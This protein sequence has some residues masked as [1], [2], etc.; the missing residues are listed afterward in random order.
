V[1]QSDEKVIERIE[2]SNEPLKF[3]DLAVK[4]VEISP[5]QKFSATSLAE[6]G[7]GKAEDWLENL[8][9]SLKNR[10]NKQIVYIGLALQFPET[11]GSGPLMVYALGIGIPPQASKDEIKYGNPLALYPGDTFSYA[12]SVKRLELIKDFLALRKFQIIEMNKAVIKLTYVIFDDGM[13][14]EQGYYYRPNPSATGGYE[15]INQ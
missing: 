9:F 11:E 8:E 15:R 4:K 7:G 2:L 14:W 6:K 13:K 5:G 10:S 1:R 3:D 12:L